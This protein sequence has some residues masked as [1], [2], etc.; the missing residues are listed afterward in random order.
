MKNK[1]MTNTAA[2]HFFLALGVELLWL[3]TGICI[4]AVLISADKV[5]ETIER[6]IEYLLLGSAALWGSLLISPNG[7]NNKALVAIIG[8]AVLIGILLS[9]GILFFEGKTEGIVWPSVSVMIGT[10]LGI[11]II[12]NTGRSARKR[13]SNKLYKLYNR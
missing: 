13:K 9:V 1:K 11:G 12:S 2:N 5:N 3:F 10:I 6:S 7:G 4:L 8:A